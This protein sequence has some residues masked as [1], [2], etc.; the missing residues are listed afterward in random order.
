MSGRSGVADLFL[1]QDA[2]IKLLSD[3]EKIAELQIGH[4]GLIG[5]KDFWIAD[6]KTSQSLFAIDQMNAVGN[7]NDGFGFR[8]ILLAEVDDLVAFL[9]FFFD[10]VLGL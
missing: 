4:R 3:R 8:M 2:G 10:D 5:E 7:G 1:D 6:L 9:E